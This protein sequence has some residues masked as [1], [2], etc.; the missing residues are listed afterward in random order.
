M[1]KASVSELKNNLSRYLRAVRNGEPVQ[2]TDREAPVALLVGLQ[3]RTELQSEPRARLARDGLLR[4]GKGPVPRDL[5]E[6]G[7]VES[8]GGVLDALLD[9]RASGR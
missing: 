6:A 9:E 7:P 2:I 3:D 1:K 5:I 8:E 4:L